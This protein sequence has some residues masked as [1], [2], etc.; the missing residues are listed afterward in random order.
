M[1]RAGIMGGKNFKETGSAPV[2]VYLKAAVLREFNKKAPSDSPVTNLL[3][4]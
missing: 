4:T 2:E 1:G 3:K